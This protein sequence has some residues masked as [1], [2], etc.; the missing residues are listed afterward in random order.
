MFT[1]EPTEFSEIDEL[2]IAFS[3]TALFDQYDDL[4][5]RDAD[6]DGDYDNLYPLLG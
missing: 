2:L 4:E 5:G 6:N 1:L 3:P